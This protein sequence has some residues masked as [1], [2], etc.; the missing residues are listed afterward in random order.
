M[1][2]TITTADASRDDLDLGLARS[3]E[4]G[5]A[6]LETEVLGTVEDSGGL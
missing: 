5:G 4:G 2:H 1:G 6:L 3:G